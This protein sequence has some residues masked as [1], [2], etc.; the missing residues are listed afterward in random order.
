QVL[1]QLSKSTLTGQAYTCIKNTLASPFTVTYDP[2]LKKQGAQDAVLYSSLDGVGFT[3]TSVLPQPTKQDA[4]GVPALIVASGAKFAAWGPVGMVNA[5]FTVDASSDVIFDRGVVL[6]SL[7]A[8]G[9]K[10]G[11]PVFRLDGGRRTMLL[12]A[13]EGSKR[14]QALVT[15][16][17][18][19]TPGY[20]AR[21]KRWNVKR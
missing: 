13:T 9:G 8:N 15:V 6:R 17:D 16:T 10:P 12:E 5:D 14:M 1:T 3:L 21:I 19:A 4:R 18:Y 2:Q 20:W 7:T 11:V